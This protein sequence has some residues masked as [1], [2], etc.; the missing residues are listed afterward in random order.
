MIIVMAQT[1]G[2]S[3]YEFCEA[4]GVV[5]Y[6]NRHGGFCELR[7]CKLDGHWLNAFESTNQV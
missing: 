6:N 7:T 1:S 4:S 2:L 3:F 5:V